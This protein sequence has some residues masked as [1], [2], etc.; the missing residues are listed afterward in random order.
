MI[1]AMKNEGL[2]KDEEN[3]GK[4][5]VSLACTAGNSNSGEMEASLA[6]AGQKKEGWRLLSNRNP[7]IRML[8]RTKQ[9]KIGKLAFPDVNLLCP[10]LY[11]LGIARYPQSAPRRDREYMAVRYLCLGIEPSNTTSFYLYH[12]PGESFTYSIALVQFERT[13]HNVKALSSVPL[14]ISSNPRLRAPTLN[15]ASSV[16][17]DEEPMN[18]RADQLQ[19]GDLRRQNMKVRIADG[20]RFVPRIEH[21]SCASNSR[22]P[23]LPFTPI[24]IRSESRLKALKSLLAVLTTH[25]PILAYVITPLTN[26]LRESHHTM[27]SCRKGNFH[28]Y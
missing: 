12:V 15:L 10:S 4:E 2:T 28:L 24:P 22:G 25:T 14:F 1:R 17:L 5:G 16:H 8:Q 18:K 6:A 3:G 23:L 7:K 13:Y 9:K 11:T 27:I 19:I 21:G 26:T 20:F